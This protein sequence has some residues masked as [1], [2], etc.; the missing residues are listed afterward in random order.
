VYSYP[1]CPPVP[2]RCQPTLRRS[3]AHIR[4]V[5]K[6]ARHTT[7]DKRSLDRFRKSL[8]E[9]RDALQLRLVRVRRQSPGTGLSDIK[10]EGDRANASLEQEMSV[11]EQ[12]QAENLLRAVNA[13][14][15][16]IDGGTF[17]DC[18]NCAQEISAKRLE[19]IPWTQYCITC[20][21]LIDER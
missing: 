11:L 2:W 3:A 7:M 14:M 5:A 18:L 21:E 19:A 4:V 16:R 20:Q 12:T 6:L 10:D 13:A 9:R 17:G 8:K 15:D 1:E